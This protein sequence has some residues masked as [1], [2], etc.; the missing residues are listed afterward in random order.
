MGEG[1]YMSIPVELLAAAGAAVASTMGTD[2]YQYTRTR[3]REMIDRRGAAVEDEPAE[4]VRLDTLAQA[5]AALE[6]DQRPAMMR[7]VQV[8]VEGILTACLD[9]SQSAALQDLV[10]ALNDQ[11]TQGSTVPNQIVSGN[12]VGGNINAAGRDNNF[13]VTR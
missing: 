12:F 8:P 6:P 2:V 5:V 3:L 1:R 11:L 4:L 13:G 9:D 7:G 10:R